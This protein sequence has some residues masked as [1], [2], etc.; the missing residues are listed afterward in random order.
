MIQRFVIGRPF[1]TESVVLDLPAETGPVPYLTPDG[2]GWQYVMQE[3]DIV[4]GLGEMPRG[5]NK[6]GWHYET[7]N[8]DESE[9]GEN[10][11][12]YYAAHNFLLISPADGSGCIGIFV[13]FPGKVSYDIGYTRHPPLRH[14]RAELCTLPHH[15][16]YSGRGRKGIPAA[17]RPQL[18]PAQVGVRSGPEPLRLQD[19]GRHPGGGR[20]VQ[21]QRPAAGHDLHGH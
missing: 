8:T 2:D 9:H 14:G 6:R 20:A 11:L 21:G 7:N 12:S 10:R 17:H 4:Y 1:P 18:Y 13:D 19:G 16:P 5:L 3:K 15:S